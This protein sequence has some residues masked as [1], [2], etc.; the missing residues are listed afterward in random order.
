MGEPLA[1]GAYL[2]RDETS[3]I[4]R[5]TIHNPERRNAFRSSFGSEMEAHLDELAQDDDIKVVI[6]RGSGGTFTAGVDL[7]EA[8]DWY[9]KAE[10]GQRAQRRPSQRR[11]LA[12]D[13]RGQRLFHEFLGFPKVTICQV[14]SYALGL[15]FEF[16]L[17]ADMVV[18]GRGA[19]LGMPA[20]TFLGPIL[21]NLHV[22]FHRLGPV[23]TK[24]LL[25]TGRMVEARE[26]E[27][28]GLFTRFVEDDDVETTTEALAAQVAKMPAD[29]IHMAKEAYRLVESS[30]GLGLEEVCSYLFHSYGTNLRF[31]DDE[32][33]FVRTR[34]QVGTSKAFDLRDRHYEDEGGAG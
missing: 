14:E 19:K 25:L 21:G 23:L 12:V 7:S 5:I 22:F 9:G 8:Y 10:D 32:F 18:V 29:G 2:E 33:N 13:R 15:G 17:M 30:M 34:A 1:P 4:A 31:E 11:R 24:D 28:L 3:H 27:H 16:A 20:T 6:L 26:V